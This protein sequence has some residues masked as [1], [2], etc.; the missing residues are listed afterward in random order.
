MHS[1]TAHRYYADKQLLRTEIA[2]EKKRSNDVSYTESRSDLSVTLNQ[3]GFHSFI[4][5][6]IYSNAVEHCN[7]I[8]AAVIAL[9]RW[10]LLHTESGESHITG[11]L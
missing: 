8:L 3:P 10:Y 2:K 1:L 6:S 5:Q 7:S 4:Y 11:T 9:E